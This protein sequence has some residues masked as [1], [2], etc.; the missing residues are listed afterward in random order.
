MK[1]S[2]G[3]QGRVFV[4][5]L[6][7]GE[8]IHESIEEFAADRRITSAVVWAVGAADD[9]SK[10]VVGPSDPRS[11]PVKPLETLLSGVHEIAAVGTIF[12]NEQGRPILHMHATCGRKEEARTG[13]IRRGVKVWKMLEVVIFEMIDVQ[14]RRE[15]DPV[16]GFQMLN[17]RRPTM[18]DLSTIR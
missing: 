12:P 16:T 18:T 7:N 14:A 4:L 8:I 2:Q 11:T 13:C 6:E 1:Y 3:K 15:L 5:Q 10:L 17:P 9:G